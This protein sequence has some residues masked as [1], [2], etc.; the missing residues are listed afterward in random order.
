[1][2]GTQVLGPLFAA[3]QVLAGSWF[4]SVE[5]LGLKSDIVIREVGIPS[6]GLA[7]CA[8]MPTLTAMFLNCPR[9]SEN[10][11]STGMASSVCA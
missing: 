1:M 4:G 10:S 11:E 2:T 5:Q 8:V 9:W 7:S 6:R 3:S